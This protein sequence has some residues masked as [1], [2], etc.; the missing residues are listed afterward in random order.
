MI[1]SK[2]QDVVPL[3]RSYYIHY[4]VN[5][6]MKFNEGKRLHLKQCGFWGKSVWIPTR[7]LNPTGRANSKSNS[8]SRYIRAVHHL[9]ALSVL[10]DLSC[11]RQDNHSYNIKNHHH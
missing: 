2:A 7:W 8:S 10:S 11:L 3:L 5:G 9:Y 6:L 1:K 4:D